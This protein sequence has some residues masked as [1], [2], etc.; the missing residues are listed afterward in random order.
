MIYLQEDLGTETL[1]D[2]LKTGRN[3]GD[4]SKEEK[5][6]LEKAVCTLPHI[7]VKGYTDLDISKLIAPSAFDTQTIL[8]DLNY[9]KYC[10]LKTT[11]VI[12]DEVALQKDF[13]ALSI[14]LQNTSLIGFMYRDFQA[15]NIMLHSNNALGFID[16]QGGKCGPYAYD[17][18]SFL[19]QA[20]S[21]YS[22]EL[23]H[24]LITHYFKEL[25]TLVDVNYKD[26]EHDLRCC[27]L[28]RLL[29]VLGAYG[30]RGK[31]E[32]KAHFLSSIIPALRSLKYEIEQG[33]CAS[34]PYLQ[35]VLKQL[36]ESELQK[37]LPAHK[38]L[39]VRVK[40]FSYKQ[41]IPYDPSGNGGGYV[42]DC[43]STHNP[44]RY[45]PYKKMTGLDQPVIDFLEEDGEISEFLAHVLPL[46]EHHVEVYMKRGFTDLMISFGCTG[47][48]HRSVYCAQHVAQYLYFKYGIS[49]DLEHCEQKIFQSFRKA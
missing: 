26:F 5:A 18:V 35:E 17:L 41:G 47:G 21:K 25:Q 24:Q 14:D 12:F 33:V 45:A 7:Q 32:Q 3:K 9:F 40:S 4:Y 10:F 38:E 23:K 19:W 29:Q 37:E 44:G 13:E 48:Q 27:I 1:F 39:L 11:D 6:L 15:R 2:A 49:V 43:R 22:S 31:F 28:F 34:Y 20:S 30:L 46:V 8:F 42:F 16:Y 36:V